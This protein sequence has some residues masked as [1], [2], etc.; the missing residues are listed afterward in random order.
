MRQKKEYALIKAVGLFW[1]IE[2]KFYG[3]VSES[4]LIE[5]YPANK[6]LLFTRTGII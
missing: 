2:E 1:C 3:S 6:F 4:M 5:W